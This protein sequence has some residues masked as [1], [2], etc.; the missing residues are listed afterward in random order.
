MAAMAAGRFS[1]N[2]SVQT[3][4][5]IATCKLSLQATPRVMLGWPSPWTLSTSA[6][7]GIAKV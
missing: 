4:V 6:H 7:L 3:A 2:L 5:S 1:N